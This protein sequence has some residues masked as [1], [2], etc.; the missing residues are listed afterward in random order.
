MHLSITVQVKWLQKPTG[1]KYSQLKTYLLI[2]WLTESLIHSHSYIYS[3]N[4]VEYTLVNY[5]AEPVTQN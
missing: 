2:L 5:Y 3:T 1:I 4:A